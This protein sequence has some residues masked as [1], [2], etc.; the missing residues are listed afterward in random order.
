MFD[1]EVIRCKK[2][3]QLP[4]YIKKKQSVINVQNNDDNCFI[5]AILSA[6]HPADSKVAQSVQSISL[7]WMNSTVKDWNTP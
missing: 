3:L 5:L 2:H 1:Y 7:S 6:L 4:D